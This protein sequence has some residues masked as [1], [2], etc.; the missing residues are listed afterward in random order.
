MPRQRTHHSRRTYVF[1]DDFPDRLERFKE[2]SSLPWAE[3]NRRLGTDPHT[4]RRWTEGRTRPNTQHMMALLDLADDLGLGHTLTAWSVQHGM[5]GSDE[6]G[7]GS[8]RVILS[9]PRQPVAGVQR[10]MPANRWNGC[11]PGAE[12]KQDPHTWT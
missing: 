1:P 10:G 11:G 4:I 6:S 2:E 9:R 8:K 7:R 5:S 12:T 3:I